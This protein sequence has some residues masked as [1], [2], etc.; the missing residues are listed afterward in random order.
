MEWLKKMI[1]IITIF[2][3]SIIV[4]II[5]AWYHLG[6]ILC[7]FLFYVYTYIYTYIYI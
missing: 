7:P 4:I 1:T 2:T 3:T 6:T 5:V